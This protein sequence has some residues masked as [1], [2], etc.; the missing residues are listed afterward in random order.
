ME[1][2]HYE[3]G[4]NILKYGEYSDLYVIASIFPLTICFYFMV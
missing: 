2:K 1:K 3:F 4:L